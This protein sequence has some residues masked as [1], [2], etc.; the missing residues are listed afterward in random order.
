MKC[1]NIHRVCFSCSVLEVVTRLLLAPNRRKFFH[2]PLNLIDMVSVVP[3]YITLLFDLL[4]GSESELGDVG[5][6]M[7]VRECTVSGSGPVCVSR[8]SFYRPLFRS[9]LL[10][11]T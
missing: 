5:R 1:S 9:P 7:Q 2:H 4:L 6:L 8:A 11:N 10:K 3:I